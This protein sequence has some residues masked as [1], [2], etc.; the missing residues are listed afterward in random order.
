[1]FKT[2]FRPTLFLNQTVMGAW[3]NHAGSPTKSVV[4]RLF[5]TIQKQAFNDRFS[6]R[7]EIF[8]SESCSTSPKS[9]NSLSSYAF[10]DWYP[11]FSR[12]FKTTCFVQSSDT[13]SFISLLYC[14]SLISFTLY[15]YCQF[16]TYCNVGRSLRQ[17]RNISSR[18]TESRDLLQWAIN[19]QQQRRRLF[20]R[21]S[22][23]AAQCVQLAS[24][25]PGYVCF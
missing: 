21:N 1:M 17:R 8:S 2:K 10:F 16:A 3:L 6:N 13:C 11:L 12:S 7:I 20:V 19:W 15:L 18:S 24:S 4:K 22:E 5:L 25:G 9:G 23:V 14:F